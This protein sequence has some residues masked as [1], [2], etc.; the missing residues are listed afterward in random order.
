VRSLR[1]LAFNKLDSTLDRLSDRTIRGQVRHVVT[2]IERVRQTVALLREGRV[3]EV[4][5]V[6]NASH[7]SMRDDFGISCAEL[8]VAVREATAHGALGARM[9]GGGFGGSAI[10][11]LPTERTTEVTSAVLHGFADSGF[12]SPNCFAVTARGP[13]RRES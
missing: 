13:A 4:G 11:L 8:D 10:V 2:E 12:G 3:A 6:F 5:S 1:E 7:A 9:T